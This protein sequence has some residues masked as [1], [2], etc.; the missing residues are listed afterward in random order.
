MNKI[1]PETDIPCLI[2]DC[3]ERGIDTADRLSSYGLLNNW[4]G[5]CLCD[6]KVF[7]GFLLDQGF[8][9]NQSGKVSI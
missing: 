6:K 9:V 7:A 8:A 2:I 3:L 1:N 4:Q 5:V